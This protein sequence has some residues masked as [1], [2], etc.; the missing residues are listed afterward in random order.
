[1]QTRQNPIMSLLRKIE[2]KLEIIENMFDR[3]KKVESATIARLLRKKMERGKDV[4]PGGRVVVPNKYDINVSIDEHKKLQLVQDTYISLWKQ[5]LLDFAQ[6]QGYILMSDPVIRLHGRPGLKQGDIIIEANIE[7]PR[8]LAATANPN[9]PNAAP[10]GTAMLTPEQ[11][12]QL[13]QQLAAVQPAPPAP[14][15]PQYSPGDWGNPPQPAAPVHIPQALPPGTPVPEAWL[16]IRI[17]QGGQEKYLIRKPEIR[18][19]RQRY[20]DIVVEDKRVSRD[21]AKILYLNGHFTIYDAG[22]TN[23]ITVNGMPHMR[24]HTLSNGDHFTIGSYDFS[25]QRL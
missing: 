20:N 18:I 22:S 16:T 8:K 3:S 11:L 21:H 19:G 15:Q 12:A 5:S 24:Q 23:G 6:Q 1:M 4:G 2:D 10:M 17:P 25:F 9:D 7:D 13:K 14:S